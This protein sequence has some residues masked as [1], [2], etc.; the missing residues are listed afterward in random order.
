MRSLGNCD[1]GDLDQQ[2]MELNADAYSALAVLVNLIERGERW[3]AI[4]L[5][6]LEAEPASGQDEVLYSCFVVA[7]G[8][9]LFARPPTTLERRGIYRLT[10][11]PQSMRM[12]FLMQAA[13]S[14]C[15][16]KRPPLLEWMTSVRFDLLMTSAAE[17]A[18][19]MNGGRDWAVQVAFI[20]SEDGAEYRERL[21]ESLKQRFTG[22]PQRP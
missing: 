17:V 20:L 7:M 21:H 18:W 19:G 9:Y 22:R 4:K 2:T 5:L 11:P 12:N 3:R 16:Q 15:R 1:S 10:H 8:G 6:R 14:W 13:D